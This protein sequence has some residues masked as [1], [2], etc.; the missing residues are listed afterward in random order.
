MVLGGAVAALLAHRFLSDSDTR[1]SWGFR[2]AA[3]G[4]F[5]G[6]GLFVALLFTTSAVVGVVAWLAG[7][8]HL[9]SMPTTYA[10]PHLCADHGG[11]TDDLDC[12]T[13]IATGDLELV[14][15]RIVRGASGRVIQVR[16]AVGRKPR[17]RRQRQPH[18]QRPLDDSRP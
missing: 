9:A 3:P 17:R 16:T 15:G 8:S 12:S 18:R 13:L 5:L 7:P 2:G 6:G 11:E 4:V 10:A 14:D 1:R